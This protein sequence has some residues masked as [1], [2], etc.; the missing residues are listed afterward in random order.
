MRFNLQKKIALAGIVALTI[1]V[2]VV[3]SIAK[4][5]ISRYSESIEKLVLLAEYQQEVSK[6]RVDLSRIMLLPNYFLIT[7]K[8][9]YLNDFNEVSQVLNTSL[10][11]LIKNKIVLTQGGKDS[12]AQ[13]KEL[14]LQIKQSAEELFALRAL[15]DD[16]RSVELIKEINFHLGTSL[17]EYSNKLNE[18]VGQKV[19]EL[20]REAEGT[21]AYVWKLLF[22][23]FGLFY[24]GILLITFY[25]AHIIVRPIN[26]VINA[27]K[28]IAEGDLG[29]AITTNSKD[30]IGDLGRSFNEM[31]ENLRLLAQ[32]AQE[33]AQGDLTKEVNIKGDL[34]DSFNNM[35]INLRQ[36]IEGVQRAILTIRSATS[37]I[38]S[39]I[40]EQASGSVE[41]A[42]SI[43]EI[44]A[45][46]EELSKT[47]QQIAENAT[48][49][50]K[51]AWENSNNVQA[52]AEIV[53]QMT[54]AMSRIKD[55]ADE[56]GRKT[57]S[58][59]ERSQR[60]G[61]IVEMIREIADQ[62]HLL[63]LN[64]VI[65]A[66]S[67]GEYGKRFSV[68]ATEVRRLAERVR[69]STDEI[70]GII[71][72]I[73]G[74]T[75]ASVL[76]TEQ[77]VREVEEGVILVKKVESHLYT[78]ANT[79]ETMV[80]AT[81]QITSVTQQQKIASEQVAVTMREISKVVNEMASSMKQSENAAADLNKMTEEFEG[82][83]SKLFKISKE[84]GDG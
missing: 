20:Q 60:V 80:D 67:A 27:S 74:A 36:L 69:G 25:L 75:N 19:K 7:G 4:Y 59:S 38:L 77:E 35:V 11:H 3:L 49:V 78:I 52:S 71:T 31:A 15:L 42:T 26:S 61:S 66:A 39:A 65:E 53:T 29:E 45:T 47:A 43:S 83:M 16:P 2:I 23:G 9:E 37:Q 70:Q 12:L 62:T 14:S 58:L 64:A 1:I 81:K 17:T 10:N 54:E 40:E 5:G 13:I 46:T 18:A 63:A 56:L 76:A 50:E 51:I 72:D 57:L 6:I 41:Q 22:G 44:T 32:Q 68:V 48:T 33:I 24:P 73:Q 55:K 84:K 79:I 82:R 21:T 30:E 8:G 28:R 34:A